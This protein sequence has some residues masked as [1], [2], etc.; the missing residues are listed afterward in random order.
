MSRFLSL[1]IVICLSSLFGGCGGRNKLDHAMVTPSGHHVYLI[2]QGGISGGLYTEAD[3]MQAFDAA[4]AKASVQVAATLN[5]SIASVWHA[6]K[7][8]GFYW[9]LW[10]NC[11]MSDGEFPPPGVGPWVRPN[12]GTHIDI[13][14]YEIRASVTQSAVDPASPAW[15]RW[16]L[17][18]Y[19]VNGVVQPTV[20]VWGEPTLA[21]PFPSMYEALLLVAK[22]GGL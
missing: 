21:N 8:T 19:P 2:D 7:Q 22:L 18:N 3:V 4:F 6:E 11:L 16:T 17:G 15:T 1:I 9:N 10:D 14:A 20:Y 5:V 13:C 12:D